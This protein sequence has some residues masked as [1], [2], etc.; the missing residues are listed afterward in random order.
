MKNR[1]YLDFSGPDQDLFPEIPEPEIP[2]AQ[3]LERSRN[4]E[5]EFPIPVSPVIHAALRA[6]YAGGP[7]PRWSADSFGRPNF[8]YES[9]NGIIKIFCSPPPDFGNR[10]HLS[11]EI[12]YSPRLGFIHAGSL[13]ESVGNLSVETADI[14]MILM[15]RIARLGDPARDIARI[16]LEEISRFR[17]VRVRHGSTRR[18]YHDFQAEV[19]RI[20]DLRLT[21]S[22]RDFTRKGNIV[23]GN[24]R[25]DRLLDLIDV[26]YSNDRNAW[27]A[28][29]FRC[30]QAFSHFLN[31]EG[32]RW[33]GYYSRSL[34]RLSPYQEAFTKKLG[35]YWTLIGIASGKKGS[36]PQATPLSI[37][38]FCEE[39][40]SWRNPGQILDAFIDSHRRL[41]ELGVLDEVLIPEP[42][43]RTKGYF[44]SWLETPLTVKL[45]EQIWKIESLA[46]K[47]GTLSLRNRR[48]RGEKK[49]PLLPLTLPESP[50]SIQQNP[51][52]I[53]K[54]RTD[55]LFRQSDLARMLG[56]TRQTLSNYERGLRLLTPDIAKRIFQIWEKRA[57]QESR[58]L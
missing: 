53:K 47:K 42:Q 1:D 52:L 15:A 20:A 45:S 50:W 49:Q 57:F 43:A 33:V 21:M 5:E 2:F 40:I 23:F 55:Y 31:P 56:V 10:F 54:F 35:T 14:F 3:D 37:L 48:A 27:T 39:E 32:L 4:S 26:E 13:W 58:F 18:L 22:W 51:E 25:P 44:R 12:F 46:E 17:G 38:E 24:H 6:F 41:Q 7:K 28:F 30:G 36:R 9:R 19:L 29:R 11:K 8:R 16:S 34:L